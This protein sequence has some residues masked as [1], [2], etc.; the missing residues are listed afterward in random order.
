MD[1]DYD[2]DTGHIFSVIGWG[3]LTGS[4]QWTT[5]ISTDHGNT[6]AET[7]EWYTTSGLIAVDAAMVADWL[8]VGYVTGEAANEFRLRRCRVANGTS[9]ATYGFQVVMHVGIAS[10]EELAVL[11]N[12]DD[13][14]NRI[15]C[16][17]VRND[18]PLR[19]AWD[20]DAGL[21]F[22]SIQVP[23]SV[24]VAGGLSATWGNQ[25]DCPDYL[26]ISCVGPDGTIYVLQRSSSDW[27]KTAIASTVDT[28]VTTSIS[29]YG[30]NIICT[31]E[32]PTR[33][34]SRPRFV[35]S[36]RPPRTR[37]SSCSTFS[38]AI[39]PRSWTKPSR[40]ARTRSRL[41]VAG[42]RAGCISIG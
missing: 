30:T 8:Y 11:T 7:Y 15:Y 28:S 29:A 12:A 1:I 27:T 34:G 9:D 42:S 41:R 36:C 16:I 38:D 39:S 22:E 5:N 40:R 31:Y 3:S 17:G 26:H 20:D 14:D 24:I 25:F 2:A 6:W 35:S 4:A 10:S 21:S 13:F 18:S 23:N 37:G 32:T 19:F 33:S